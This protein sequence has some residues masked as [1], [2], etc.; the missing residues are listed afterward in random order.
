MPKTAKTGPT[1][2]K[3]KSRSTTDYHVSVSL[4]HVMNQF[5]MSSRCRTKS[6]KERR[7]CYVAQIDRYELR[8]ALKT[9]NRFHRGFNVSCAP[10]WS[11]DVLIERSPASVILDKPNKSNLTGTSPPWRRWSL[12]YD[13]DPRSISCGIDSV[14]LEFQRVTPDVG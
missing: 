3:I 7:S 5:L 9:I 11:D 1:Q 2:S 4:V 10:T 14:E 12:T 8:A 6:Q 13:H